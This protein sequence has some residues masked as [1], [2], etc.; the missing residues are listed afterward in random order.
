MVLSEARV[1]LHI[2]IAVYAPT[3][4][5]LLNVKVLFYAKLTSVADS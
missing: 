4:I 5:C 1:W 3:D 2:F